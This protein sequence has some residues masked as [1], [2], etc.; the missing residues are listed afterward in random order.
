MATTKTTTKKRTRKKTIAPAPS[1][2][3]PAFKYIFPSIRGVQAQREY[4]VSMVPLGLIPKIF[5]FDEGELA[6]E[7]RAQRTL[8]KARIPKIAQYILANPA[9]YVFS[10]ITASVDGELLFQPITGN[11]HLGT[12][13]VPMDAQFIINDGQHRRAAIEHALRENLDLRDE[14]ISVVFFLDIKLERSQQMF[15]D[16]NRHATRPS[17]TLGILYDHRDALALITKRVVN[18][19]PLLRKLVEME[20]ATP[21]ARSQRLFAL[22][23]LYAGTGALLAGLDDPSL[24]GQVKLGGA[25]WQEV[26]RQFP[27]WEQVYEGKLAAR[28]VRQDYVHGHGVVIHALGRAGNALLREVKSWKRQLRGLRTLDWSRSNTGL[29][30]GRAMI[31]GRISKASTNVILTTNLI[32]THLGLELSPEEMRIERALNRG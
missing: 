10:S 14:T 2:A 4:Y 28:E 20:R 3:T 17:K 19:T 22:G 26:A 9:T 24:D 6:P 23:A 12:L 25:Y 8:S 27:E 16:L 7:L 21:A 18:A 15:A 31:G 30:E 32:K 1:K 13:H 29:W 11:A 5:V